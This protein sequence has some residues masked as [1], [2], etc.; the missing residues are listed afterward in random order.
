MDYQRISTLT[1]AAIITGAEEVPIVQGGVTKRAVASLIRAGMSV[2]DPAAGL[3]RFGDGRDGVVVVNSAITLARD[4][5]YVDLSIVAGGSINTAGYKIFVSG[6]LDLSAAPAD[7]I[8]RAGL[9]ATNKVN[10]SNNAGGGAGVLTS[11]TCGGSQAGG[12]GAAGEVVPL[13]PVAP[14]SNSPGNGGIGGAGGA[15][16]G[17]GV[18]PGGSSVSPITPTALP[19]RRFAQDIV[20][21]S[22]LILGGAGGCGG[23]G[24]VIGGGGG[25]GSGGGVVFIS[26]HTIIR[27]AGT[28]VA[29]ISVRGGD[30]ANGSTQTSGNRGGGGAGGGGGGG[31]IYLCYAYLTGAVGT[32]ILDASGGMGGNGGSG[33]GT[34]FGADGGDGAAGGRFTIINLTTGVLIEI[35]ETLIAGSP[36][37]VG[38][39]LVGGTGGAGHITRASL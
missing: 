23:G 28:A 17:D 27:G 32:D 38:V 22:T 37:S 24:G 4:M 7:A 36:G 31:W 2:G 16:G 25:G 11:Q 34:G 3:F 6:T 33:F 1:P 5:Y 29:C 15:G 30:G 26:A 9:K 21:G 39:G 19:F 12:N 10:N 18:D 20:R 35:D 8:V 13:P 14:V